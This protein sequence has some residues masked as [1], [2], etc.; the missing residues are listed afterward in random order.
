MS[1]ATN[2]SVKTVSVD[3]LRVRDLF[4]TRAKHI[5]IAAT[6]SVDTAAVIPANFDGGVFEIVGG[7]TITD[8]N[9]TLPDA[10]PVG[11]SFIAVLTTA[12]GTT[13]NDSEVIFTPQTAAHKIY[14]TRQEDT[15]VLAPASAQSAV[16]FNMSAG[17]AK[18]DFIRF[19]RLSNAADT[20]WLAESHTLVAGGVTP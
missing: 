17:I 14:L 1:T 16:R 12:A 13:S 7:A 15:A 2:L 11:S 9:V 6:A 8:H 3:V 18:G 4:E 10:M 20:Y 5:K 19:T